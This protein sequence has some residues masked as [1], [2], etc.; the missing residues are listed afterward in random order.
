MSP[1]IIPLKGRKICGNSAEFWR[2]RLF[3]FELRRGDTQLG[4]RLSAFLLLYASEL[5]SH[6]VLLVQAPTLR[7]SVPAPMPANRRFTC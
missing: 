4:P 6:G 2:Q 3:A 1:Q 5:P 7:K